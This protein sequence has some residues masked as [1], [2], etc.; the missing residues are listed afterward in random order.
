MPFARTEPGNSSADWPPVWTDFNLAFTNERGV[1]V[2]AATLRKFLYR[3]LA[4][5]GLPRVRLHAL[6]HSMATLVLAA[7]EHPR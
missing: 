3:V 7:G 5:A 4:D 1:Q 2:L 6:R